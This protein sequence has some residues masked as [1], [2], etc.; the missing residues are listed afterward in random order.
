[1]T[2]RSW[3]VSKMWSKT[4]KTELRDHPTQI[5]LQSIS[6]VRMKA[7]KNQN[8]LKSYLYYSLFQISL[9]PAT[10]WH[11]ASNEE[12]Y[13]RGSTF[14]A[15]INNERNF[16]SDYV[17]NLQALKRMV[18]VKYERD[19]SVTPNESTWFGYYDRSGREY[20]LER[21]KVY[22]ND[23]LGLQQMIQQGKL[24]RIE[25]PCEHLVLKENWFRTNI[26]PIL[27]EK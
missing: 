17:K 14:L 19:I 20:P 16:N 27:S 10:Y 24:L 2:A 8:Q 18:L 11:D 4:W 13:K 22:K 25:S 1:M 7:S 5:E 15:V 6:A 23:T 26:I 3:S 9:T 21:T 12:N